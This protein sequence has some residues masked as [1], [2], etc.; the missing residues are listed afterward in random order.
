M[1]IGRVCAKISGR[2]SGKVCAIVDVL[3]ERFVVIDGDVKRKKCNVKH[4]EPLD[5]TIEIKKDA[6][7]EDIVKKLNLAGFKVMGKKP[8]REAKPKQEEK[9]KKAVKSK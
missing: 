6:K 4:L 1:D 3:D 2:E 5:K 7:T 9:V 8:V